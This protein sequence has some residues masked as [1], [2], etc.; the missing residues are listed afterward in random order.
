MKIQREMLL[1]K[2]KK[3]RKKIPKNQQNKETNDQD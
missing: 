2:I 3:K 1:D